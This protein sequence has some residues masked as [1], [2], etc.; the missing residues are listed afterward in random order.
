MNLYDLKRGFLLLILSGLVVFG[1]LFALSRAWNLKILSINGNNYFTEKANELILEL[2]KPEELSRLTEVIARF[3]TVSIR[4]QEGFTYWHFRKG[5]AYGPVIQWLA[6]SSPIPLL[7]GESAYESFLASGSGTTPVEGLSGLKREAVPVG[8]VKSGPLD[9]KED[10]RYLLMDFKGDS[11]NYSGVWLTEGQAGM[12]GLKDLE[13]EGIVEII[14]IPYTAFDLAGDEFLSIEYLFTVSGGVLLLAALLLA[15]RIWLSSYQ[16]EIR[17]RRLCGAPVIRESIGV[18]S[19]YIILLFLGS[20][21]GLVGYFLY[22]YLAFGPEYPLW[23]WI[24]A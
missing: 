12:A 9:P 7:L 8:L 23:G 16:W 10:S 24:S 6:V 19:K 3:D 15:S 22:A 4:T 11:R 18:G 5:A 20:V 1:G 21:V 14:P 17:V 2:K 13:A